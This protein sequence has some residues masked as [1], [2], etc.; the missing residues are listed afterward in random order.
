MFCVEQR[1]EQRGPF[2]CTARI[3]PCIEMADVDE[4]CL[5]RRT[6]YCQSFHNSSK[7]LYVEWRVVEIIDVLNSKATAVPEHQFR[8]PLLPFQTLSLVFRTRRP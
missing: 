5:P 8:Q 7:I 2:C 1:P 3:L 6:D 4:E